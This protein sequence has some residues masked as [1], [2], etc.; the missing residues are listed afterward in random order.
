MVI[1]ELKVARKKCLVL[2]HQALSDFHW[3]FIPASDSTSSSLG[4][5]FTYFPFSTHSA[6]LYGRIVVTIQSAE[7]F[8]PL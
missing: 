5:K 3:I 1:N 4:K 8:P 2:L 6:V 7:N